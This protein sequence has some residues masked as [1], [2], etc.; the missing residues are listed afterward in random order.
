M[1]C[2]TADP[3]DAEAQLSQ[4]PE[5]KSNSHQLKIEQPGSDFFFL[6][7]ENLQEIHK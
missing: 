5:I 7:C 2:L 4:D 1:L 3:S 6:M